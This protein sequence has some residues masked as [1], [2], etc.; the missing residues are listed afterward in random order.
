MTPL[1][2]EKKILVVEDEPF[3]RELILEITQDLGLP[4][5]ALASGDEAFAFLKEKHQ[6]IGLML[7]DVR[8]PGLMD[9]V[10]LANTVH[11]KW[12]HIKIVL[13][14]GYAGEQMLKLKKPTLFLAKPWSLDALQNA[15]VDAIDQL[16]ER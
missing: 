6:E 11:E 13:S 10:D 7:S 8:M 15:I 16:K 5:L 9:G 4:A 14:S 3:T 12:P 1:P 2:Q